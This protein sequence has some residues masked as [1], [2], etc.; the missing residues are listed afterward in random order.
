MAD[1]V[2]ADTTLFAH[3]TKASRHSAS[4]ERMLGGRRLAASFQTPPE[5][6]SAG[7]GV[8]RQQRVD[9]LL[10][11]TLKLPHSEATDVWYGRVAERR[12]ALKKWAQPG[13]DASDAD[14]WII[15]SALE[16]GF[17]LFSHDKQQVQ[18]G[19]AMGLRVLTSLDGLKDDN[20]TI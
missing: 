3:L 14:M 15:S 4:Y 9:D 12:R 5:L 2:V 11:V 19:R 13:S 16:Y 10:I 1:Y 18:L 6:L 8:K 20:P 7:Y 17:P